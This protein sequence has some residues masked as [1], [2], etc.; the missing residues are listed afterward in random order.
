MQYKI[1]VVDSDAS[2]LDETQDYLT[3]EGMDVVATNDSLKALDLL[4]K[5]RFDILITDIRMPLFSGLDLIRSARG[6]N[7][8]LPIIIFSSESTHS[9]VIEAVNLNVS[10]FI[11]KPLKNLAV[12]KNIILESVD[13]KEKSTKKVEVAAEIQDEYNT[14]LDAIIDVYKVPKFGVLASGIAHNINSPLGGVIGYTQLAMM[15]NP[16]IHGLDMVNQQAVRVSQI[17]AGIS[18]KGQSE[19]SYKTTEINLKDLI[20]A[21]LE[22]L[23]FNLYFKHQVEKN[24]ILNEVPL[25]KAVYRDIAVI[26]HHILQNAQDAMFESINKILTVRSEKEDENISLSITDSGEGIPEEDISN[27]FNPG[28]TTRQRPSEAT[29]TDEPSGFGFGLL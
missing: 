10:K 25:I 12:L 4:E 26:I 9:E 28:F 23:N 16:N 14:L 6:F 8:D 21:E 17:L 18:D 7:P 27:I 13:K 15:K 11:E 24:L 5:K 19:L 2:T 1:L 29:V 22:Y 3:K 20:N